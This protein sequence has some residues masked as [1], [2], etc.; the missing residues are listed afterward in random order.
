MN[1]FFY[2]LGGIV[3]LPVVGVFIAAIIGVAFIISACTYDILKE[4]FSK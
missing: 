2:I 1:M 3:L 4:Y